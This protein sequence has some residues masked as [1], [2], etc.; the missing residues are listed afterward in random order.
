MEAL[1]E[2][3]YAERETLRRP[4]SVPVYRPSGEVMPLAFAALRVTSSGEL[5][6]LDEDGEALYVFYSP[7]GGQL[8]VEASGTIEVEV[9]E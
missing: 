4:V 3:G 8:T 7:P 1:V 6:L 9:P 5:A 2:A